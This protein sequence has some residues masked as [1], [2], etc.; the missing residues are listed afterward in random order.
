[1]SVN[2]L[3]LSQKELEAEVRRLWRREAFFNATQEIAH[4]GFC[5]WDYEHDRIKTCTQTY[6]DIFGMTIE[7]VIANHSSWD[8][9]ILQIHPED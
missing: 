3:K 6:A 1:M 7:A 4:I 9:I 2:R 5:E 8:K